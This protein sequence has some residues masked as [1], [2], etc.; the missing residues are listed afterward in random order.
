M[1]VLPFLTILA[2]A[3]AGQS[4]NA[5][6]I[7]S[8]SQYQYSSF[9]AS[10]SDVAVTGSDMKLVLNSDG[11]LI[12]STSKKYLHVGDDKKLTLAD[13]AQTGFSFKS[14]Y[15]AYKDSQAFEVCDGGK[16]EV[17]SKDSSCVSVAVSA[18][19][20]QD[21]DDVKGTDTA[22]TTKSATSSAS[23]TPASSATTA[24][25][26]TASAS[27]SSDGQKFG[28][29]AIHSGSSVQYSSIK[30]VKEHP[31]V[32]SV[33]GS[34]GEDLKLTLDTESSTLVDQ[35]GRGI[36]LDQNTGELGDVA[37]FGRQPATT[38]FSIKDGHLSYN[39]SQDWKACPSGDNAFS[40]SN[41]EC[42]GGIDIALKVVTV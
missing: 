35:D 25:S 24:H 11:S 42:T 4:F 27:G 32:F 34:A 36:N 23:V 9:K 3:L 19:S 14:N 30:K 15:L 37:P 8:G 13:D 40:L 20:P 22:S 12:D 31:H 41:K 6:I 29:V 17:D 39:G 28:L 2:T 33:G 7:R 16:I 1:Q 26:A 18:Y 38:G 21:V 5:L 10:G